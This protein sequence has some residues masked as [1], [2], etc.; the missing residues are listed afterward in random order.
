MQAL[1]I[2]WDRDVHETQRRIGVTESDNRDI[3]I[4]G[5]SNGLMI[6]RRIRND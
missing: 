4:A 2:A 5:F 3:H 6:S 1:S